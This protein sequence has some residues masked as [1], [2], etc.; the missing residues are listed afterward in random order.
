LWKIRERFARCLEQR[1]L[2][3]SDELWAP[4]LEDAQRIEKITKAISVKVVPNA[5]DLERYKNNFREKANTICFVGYYT[6]PPNLKAAHLLIE[7]IY[8]IVK[9][10]EPSATLYLVGRN[11]SPYMLKVACQEKKI[12]VTG[13]VKD[14][15]CY[16]SQASVIVVPLL[17]GG[18][19][20]FKIVEAM[21]LGK[22]IV[23]TP[24]GC[25]G[26]EVQDG[27]HLLIR[28]IEEFPEAILTL[29]RQPDLRK[30]LG[31][32]ARELV[33]EKYSWL[34]AAKIIKERLTHLTKMEF[35]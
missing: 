34:A 16:I 15:L 9:R 21:A 12:I 35:C 24:K 10:Y 30:A 32:R 28:E 33:K 18:G 25:E 13:E 11:P 22:A 17:S 2:A 23:S 8:P 20:R 3:L 7:Q 27:V 4:S 31:Y 1:F 5:V 26:I 29:F 14:A 19:T 6:Y